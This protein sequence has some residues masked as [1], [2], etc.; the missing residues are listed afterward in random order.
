MEATTDGLLDLAR[1]Q[2]RHA[3]CVPTVKEAGIQ[4]DA[5]PIEGDGL[6]KFAEGKMAVGVVKIVLDGIGGGH[7]ERAVATALTD[8]RREP[9]G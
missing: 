5:G 7:G 4:R 9:V 3:E 6:V 2:K 1:F 8:I